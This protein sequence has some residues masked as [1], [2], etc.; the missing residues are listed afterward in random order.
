MYFGIRCIFT[1]VQ[2]ARICS[3]FGYMWTLI[4]MLDGPDGLCANGITRRTCAY[5]AWCLGYVAVSNTR[6]VSQTSRAP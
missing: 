6:D 1:F 4:Y 5:G 2:Y 3:M